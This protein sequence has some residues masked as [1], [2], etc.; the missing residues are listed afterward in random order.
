MDWKCVEFTIC[1]R[2]DADCV[3]C[4]HTRRIERFAKHPVA[5]K[6]IAAKLAEKKAAGYNHVTFT[7]GEPTLYPK[8]DKLLE[9]A[10]L[11]GYRTRAVTNGRALAGA[12]YRAR[13]LPHLDE[14]CF[15]IHGADAKAH[16]RMTGSLG[17]WRLMR[18][19]LDAVCREKPELAVFVNA[20]A[21]RLNLDELA[22]IAAWIKDYAPVREYWIS[23]LVP[24]GAGRDRFAELAPRNAEVME[25]AAGIVRAA[26]R[27]AVRFY[28]FPL[29]VLGEFR[30]R[31]TDYARH[32]AV[33]VYR[34]LRKDGMPDLREAES[35]KTD[36]PKVRTDKCAGCALANR[37]GGLWR[38]YYNKFGDTEVAPVRAGAEV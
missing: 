24:Q 30:E 12:D 8:F 3:F 16:D 32:P 22:P 17:G 38:D 18:D 25:R 34:G 15:S 21:T 33:A 36:P 2:C 28:G 9:I 23:A 19:A 37:C 31:A 20:V 10:K 29:C 26:G 4:S 7:G 14:L 13:T 5:A 6:D 27:V 1:Y 11:L 35:K